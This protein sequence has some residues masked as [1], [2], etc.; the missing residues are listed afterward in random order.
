ML[1]T[2]PSNVALPTHLSDRLLQS[3]LRP[4]AAWTIAK[5]HVAPRSLEVRKLL[6]VKQVWPSPSRDVAKG[7]SH[8]AMP[9]FDDRQA[10]HYTTS[11]TTTTPI[12]A[13]ASTFNRNDQR[14]H[15]RMTVSEAGRLD[16]RTYAA[17][18]NPVELSPVVSRFG[19]RNRTCESG[20][21]S[22]KITAILH[23]CT[24]SPESRRS[25]RV[26]MLYTTYL[27]LDRN[28]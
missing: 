4:H 20:A 6:H 18:K 23:S 16:C 13:L 3:R 26:W 5:R 2:A 19:A 21:S 25:S 28:V 1:D 12:T 7:G 22:P 10:V 17:K 27:T 15:P 8:F 14:D 9:R 24:C 11:S